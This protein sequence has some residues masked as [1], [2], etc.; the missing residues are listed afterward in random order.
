MSDTL[1]IQIRNFFATQ[2][3]VKAWLFGSF[4]RGEARED[5]DMDFLVQYDRKNS[6]IGLFAMVQI[7]QELQRITG[8]EVDLVEEGTLMPFAVESAN[9]DKVLIYVRED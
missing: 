8:R 9:N 6:H 7:K 4:S 1:L 5:S 3:V 2:P